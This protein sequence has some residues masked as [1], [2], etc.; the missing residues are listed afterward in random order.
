MDTNVPYEFIRFV[1][2]DN[3]GPYDFIGFGVMNNTFPLLFHR[4]WDHAW[5]FAL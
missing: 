1:A 3:N 4:A 5:Q 2:M